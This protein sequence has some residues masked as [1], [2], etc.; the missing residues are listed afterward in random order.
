MGNVPC[1]ADGTLIS[2]FSDDAID[3]NGNFIKLHPGC[4]NNLGGPIPNFH[5]YAYNVLKPPISVFLFSF[6]R[7]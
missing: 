5:G 6:L 4:V 3:P 1:L 2:C 7:Y